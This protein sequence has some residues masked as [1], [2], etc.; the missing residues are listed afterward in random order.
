M[1]SPLPVFQS[2]LFRVQLKG[3]PRKD[4]EDIIYNLKHI[5]KDDVKRRKYLKAELK[6]FKKYRTGDYRILFSYCA[7]CYNK[8]QKEFNCSICDKNFLERIVV[9]SIDKRPKLYKKMKRK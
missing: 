1:S 9:H 8:Y 3:I 7:E 6:H 5:D 2:E 4:R